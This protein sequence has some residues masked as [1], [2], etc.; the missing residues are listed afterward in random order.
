MAGKWLKTA[1]VVLVAMMLSAC[2]A[3]VDSISSAVGDG[4][5]VESDDG[6]TN[7]VQAPPGFEDLTAGTLVDGLIP[8]LADLPLPGVAAF[9]AGA[10]FTAAQDPRET[11]GQIIFFLE[12]RADVAKFYLEELPRQGYTISGQPGTVEQVDE[13]VD[14]GFENFTL[15]FD[16][17]DGI[18]LQLNISETLALEG[19]TTMNINRFRNPTGG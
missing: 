15:Q 14:A 3:S 16:G 12:P 2:G 7:S 11:A 13:M 10:A 18:P 5:S 4:G 1:A 9:S 6:T 17:P 8:E 19:G